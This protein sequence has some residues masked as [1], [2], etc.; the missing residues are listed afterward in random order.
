MHR[1]LN[2]RAGGN[3]HSIVLFYNPVAETRVECL[4]SCL[5]PGETPKYPA[6]TVGEHL[7]QRINEARVD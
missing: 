3:R 7:M 2:N 6:C 5:E 4:P 1:V